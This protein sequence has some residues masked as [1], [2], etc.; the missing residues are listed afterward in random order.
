MGSFED[1]VAKCTTSALRKMLGADG[2]QSVAFHLG[3]VATN[4]PKTI[5]EKILSMFGPGGAVVV[6]RAIVRELFLE[7][8]TAPEA[9]ERFDFLEEMR[10][11]QRKFATL[12]RR[13]A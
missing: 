12:R 7:M 11:A 1:A 4:D 6:E 10:D 13:E 9:R 8:Q 3:L 5:H 2:E